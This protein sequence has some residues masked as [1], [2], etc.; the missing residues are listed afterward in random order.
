MITYMQLIRSQETDKLVVLGISMDIAMFYVCVGDIT[1]TKDILPLECITI[2]VF[3]AM[4][5]ADIKGNS[6]VPDPACV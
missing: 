6:L 1:N 2:V 5:Q 3:P 4:I